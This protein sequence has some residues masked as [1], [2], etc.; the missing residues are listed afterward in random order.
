V[1]V[2][3]KTGAEADIK[4]NTLAELLHGLDYQV[5]RGTA[6]DALQISSIS[7]DSRQ[8]G[9]NSLFC[10]VSGTLTDGHRYVNEAIQAGAAA[11]IIE[12]GAPVSLEQGESA[13]P[14]I[15]VADSRQVLGV[16]AARIHA[17][18]AEKM[19]MIGITGTN[20]KTTVSY[21]LEHALVAAGFCVGVIGTVDYRYN[22][23]DGTVVQYP[24]PFTTPDPL[25]LHKLLK[26]MLENGVTHVV[27]EVSSH[28]LQQQRLGPVS[29]AIGLF[30]NLSQDHLDYHKTMDDYFAA[31]SILFKTYLKQDSTAIVMMPPPEYAGSAA[32][33]NKLVALCETLPIKT[34]QCGAS[35]NAKFSCLSLTCD[36]SGISAVVVDNK[37]E[38][39][40]LRSSLVGLFNVDN[41]LISLTAL[42]CLGID[43]YQA[44]ELLS[45]AQGAPGRLQRVVLPEKPIGQPTVLVDYA[46]TP[47]ALEKVLQAVSELEPRTLFCV[48]GCGGDRDRGKR[49]LMGMLAATQSDVA[50]I[51]DDN[52]RSEEPAVIRTEILE[53][54]EGGEFEFQTPGWLAKRAASA[55][56]VVEIPDRG[57]AISA[58]VSAAGPDDIVLIA[59]KGHEKYQI[60]RSGKRF[61]DDCLAAQ[62]GSLLW[63][64][65]TIAHATGGASPSGNE[66]DRFPAVSTDSRA[67]RKRDVFVALQGDNFNG[68][69]FIGK[70]VDDGA[71][72]I[73]FSEKPAVQKDN[74]STVEVA[75]TL[76][77]LGDLAQWRRQ[78]VKQLQNPVVVGLTGSCGK[79]TVKEM[80]AAI[81][82]KRWPDKLDRPADRVIKTAG[83]FNNLIGLPLTLLPV[84]A[85]HRALVLEMG[86]NMPGEIARLAEIADPDIA[87]IL[88]IHG[89]HLE[90]L[91]TIE[92]VARAKG[93]LFDTTRESAI[94]VVNLDDDLVVKCAALHHQKTVGFAISS[95]GKARKPAVWADDIA[96]YANGHLSLTLHVQDQQAPVKI[97]APGLHNSSNACAAAAIS[98]AAGIGFD[99]IIAGLQSFRSS[100]NRMQTVETPAGLRVLNDSYN[101]N[102]ASMASALKTLALLPAKSRI[103]II[104]DMLELGEKSAALHEIIGRQAAQSKIESLGLVGSFSADTKRGAIAG[105]MDEGQI[106]IFDEK[107]RVVDWVGHL[108]HSG[109]LQPGDWILLKGSR[110]IALDTVVDQIVLKY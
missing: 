43:S 26:E 28:A 83:N 3:G 66:A 4:H 88:N 18:P 109:R 79:T 87:C 22:R 10:A 41:L 99:H 44:V 98:F 104:G 85:E 97:H 94:H 92:G 23:R 11:V 34:V 37:K 50:I 105:G 106:V 20:G 6:L 48:V 42:V 58:A 89:A 74:V 31:K 57:E 38:E 32:W 110:G 35:E 47:D 25:H 2:Q 45:G 76:T 68:H 15:T 27:M 103:A 72:C 100:V 14:V 1:G 13:I 29:F 21:L 67:I 54:L 69:E 62:Q 51:T 40:H 17:N 60:T 8:V 107:E 80:T 102:P 61:F 95:Q 91:G 75:D 16:L 24:A 63:D 86:M 39:Y 70:A 81:F 84:S 5:A 65:L 52:P 90:G 7:A 33:T 101:A 19:T 53:G 56:G 73:V 108:L 12:Q 59:G 49:P 78:A 93:E 46:H 36:L 82:A 55:Q 30:T 71:G 77:A 9:Q 64:R 96:V